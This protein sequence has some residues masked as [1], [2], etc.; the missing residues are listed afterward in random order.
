MVLTVLQHI[1]KL[2]K[3]RE[4][5]SGCQPHLLAPTILLTVLCIYLPMLPAAPSDVV[6]LNFFFDTTAFLRSH[7]AVGQ[8]D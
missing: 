4:W 5:E 7:P 6:A 3:A 8:L 2:K 1:V